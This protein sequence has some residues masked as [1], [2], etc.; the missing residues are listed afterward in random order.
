M[1]RGHRQSAVR[2][3]EARPPAEWQSCR[4]LRSTVWGRHATRRVQGGGPAPAS[5]IAQDMGTTRRNARGLSSYV[6]TTALSYQQ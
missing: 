5:K 6:L 2:K 1:G 3:I 4:K